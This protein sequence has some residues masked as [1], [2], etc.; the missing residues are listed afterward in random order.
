MPPDFTRQDLADRQATLRL[1][2][3][4]RRPVADSGSESIGRL[5]DVIV[6]LRGTDY[7][8]V[9]GLVAAVGSREVFVPIAQVSNFDS[10]PLRLSSARLSLRHFDRREGEVLLRAD[11]LGHR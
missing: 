7:P 3:L 6:R 5:A 2:R 8:L 1:S 11:V 4:L 10:D 9:T